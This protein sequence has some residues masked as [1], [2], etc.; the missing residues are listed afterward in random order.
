ME[1]SIGRWIWFLLIGGIIG[2]LAG[3]IVKGRGFGLLGDIVVGIVGGL[4][5]GW[6]ASVIGVYAYSSLAAF[7]TALIG[8]VTLVSL[9]RFFK[10]AA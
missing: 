8:A 9:T 2:W 1:Y 10:L 4:L 6:M 7:I 5:G 3:V